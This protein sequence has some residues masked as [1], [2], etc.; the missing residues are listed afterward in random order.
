MIVFMATITKPEP[1]PES[2]PLGSRSPRVARR[3]RRLRAAVLSAA[4]RQFSAR[5]VATVSVAELIA[6]ADVSRATFYQFFSSKYNLLEDILNPIFDYAV[7]RIGALTTE[8][9]RRGL[10]GIV[11]VY[12]A[13]WREHR[14]GLLLIPDIDP[15]TFRRFEARHRALNDALLRVLSAAE[16][17]GLLRNGSA[18]FSLKVIARTAIPLLRVYAGHPAGETLFADAL[19]CLLLGSPD[20]G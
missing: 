9:P 6:E 14:E 8:S 5:G 10:E 17:E 19:R 18:H 15:P 13:L 1:P 20:K 3:Q 2:A 11:E 16:H 4:A 12:L 7:E